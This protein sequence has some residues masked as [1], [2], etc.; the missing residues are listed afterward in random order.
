MAILP[1]VP[2]GSAD[3]LDGDEL[4]RLRGSIPAGNR[5]EISNYLRRCSLILAWMEYT[6]DQL[7]DE[8]GVS[9]GSAIMS[10]GIYCWRLD[11]AN[12]VETYGIA[13]PRDFLLRGQAR[14]WVPVQLD[15]DSC[16]ALEEELTKH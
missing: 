4:A 6:R 15:V 10:D 9:G 1:L 11:A 14:A 3:P 16:L 5:K 2:F 8:F 13:L 12:Y 7:G